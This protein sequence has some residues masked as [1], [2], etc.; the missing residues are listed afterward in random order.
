MHNTYVYICTCS[1]Y[2]EN[3]HIFSFTKHR[4]SGNVGSQV[5]ELLV[6]RGQPKV[7]LIVG[8]AL[9]MLSWRIGT[10]LLCGF[11]CLDW[12]RWPFVLKF[13]EISLDRREMIVA[14]WSRER[15]LTPLRAVF[16]AVKLF[17]MF[18]FFTRVRARMTVQTIIIR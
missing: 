4:F 13:S 9:R 17:C 3:N 8:L 7:V 6:R 2:C 15:L 16:V 14:G 12:K 11:L 1:W 10:L 5:A 18:T